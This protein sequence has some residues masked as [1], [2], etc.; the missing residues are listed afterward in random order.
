MLRK[1]QSI[2]TLTNNLKSY[3]IELG[4]D[5]NKITTIRTCANL[6]NFIHQLT[7][8]DANINFGFFGSADTAYDIKPVLELFNQILF[9]QQNVKLNIFTK[10]D[11]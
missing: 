7:L 8:E 9:I 1:S 5:G 6:D 2:I 3:L 10:S 4:Y 11:P